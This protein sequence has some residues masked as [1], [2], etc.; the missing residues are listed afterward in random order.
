MENASKA[1]IIAGAILLSIL[2]I[3]I[4][5]FIFNSAS[6]TMDKTVSRMSEQE[7]QTHNQKFQP[8][9]GPKRSGTDVKTLINTLIQN[10]STQVTN[11]ELGRA[12]EVN[13]TGSVTVNIPHA[14][15]TVGNLFNDILRDVKMTRTYD[16]V[17][18]VDAAGGIVDKITIT[19]Q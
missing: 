9:E 1:L 10:Y 6:D 19:E 12:P 7:K 4:A 8:F 13:Y 16:V 18:S 2:I 3:G 5:M 11:G 17:V 15:E 14:A